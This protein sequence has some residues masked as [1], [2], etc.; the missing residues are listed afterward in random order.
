MIPF[1]LQCVKCGE[2]MY[3]GA[4]RRPTTR[5]L[6]RE[7]GGCPSVAPRDRDRFRASID[8]CATARR[9]GGRARRRRGEK[10]RP[11]DRQEVQQPQGGRRRRH[12]PRHPQVPLLHQVLRL[13]QRDRVQDGP[14]EPGLRL[15]ER[16]DAQLR[17]LAPA[18]RQGEGVRGRAEGVERAARRGAALVC[19]RDGAR[20][21]GSERARKT[22][23]LGE[24]SPR[25]LVR[26]SLSRPSHTKAPTL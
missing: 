24:Q 18:G 14:A 11:P 7:R 22:R 9:G 16:R 13:Q 10:R 2:Y 12:V 19:F 17:E 8:G 20:R 6:L 21:G 5:R 1:S 23:Q 25:R 26:G 3:R 15:R 4:R